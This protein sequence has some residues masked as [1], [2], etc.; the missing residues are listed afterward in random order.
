MPLTDEQK[1]IVDAVIERAEQ[2]CRYALKNQTFESDDT[3]GYREGWEV[4]AGVCEGAIRAHV[5]N[6]IKDDLA[7]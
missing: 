1:K 7:R 3:P 5:M 4:A 6:H 2:A